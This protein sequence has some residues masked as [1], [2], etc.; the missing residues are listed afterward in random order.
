MIG[1]NK[2]LE[3][4]H[5]QNNPVRIGLIGAGQMGIDVVAQTTKMKGVRVVI[6]TDVHLDRAKAA[7]EIAGATGQVVRG[8]P[9]CRSRNASA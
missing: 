8:N 6:A 9:G 1:L 7:Y 4:R 5:I 3:Q 2:E